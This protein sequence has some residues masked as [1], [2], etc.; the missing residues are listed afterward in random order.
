[1]IRPRPV[2][3]YANREL[4]KCIY[5]FQSIFGTKS[6]AYSFLETPL[7]LEP[8]VSGGWDVDIFGSDFN[9]ENEVKEDNLAIVESE[10]GWDDSEAVVLPS[11]STSSTNLEDAAKSGFYVPVKGFPVTERWASAYR[12]AIVHVLAGNFESAARLLQDQIGV[13]NLAPFRDL[14]LRLYTKSHV[15]FTTMPNMPSFRMYPVLPETSTRHS[16]T[17]GLPRGCNDVT[18]KTLVQVHQRECHDLVTKGQFLEAVTAYRK[19]L[20]NIPLTL[21][22]TKPEATKGSEMIAVCKEYILGLQME[23]YRKTLPKEDLQDQRRSL[24]LAAYFTH[25]SMN[26]AH[27]MLALRTAM[28]LS[29]RLGY[30]KNAT[31]F[32]RRLL[33]L[34]PSGDLV[35]QTRKLLKA[36]E[37]QNDSAAEKLEYDEHNPFTVCAKSYKPIYRGK[38]GVQCSFCGAAYMPEYAGK[39]CEICTVAEIGRSVVGLRISPVQFR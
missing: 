3:A 20:L 21:V 11:P 4:L 16:Q 2:V 30:F 29:Y 15:V 19:M 39:V 8:S 17:V 33:E 35:A 24:E 22:K 9:E 10:S 37:N 7:I 25:C 1:M 27:L 26:P 31:G 34:G 12:L 13:V 6:S 23:L 32:C 5:C 18:L 28:N 36:S 14:F 38:P